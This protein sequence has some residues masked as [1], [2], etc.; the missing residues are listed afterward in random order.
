MSTASKGAANVS[1]SRR[2][3]GASRLWAQRLRTI[4]RTIAGVPDYDRYLRHVRLAHPDV[5][6]LSQDEFVSDQLRRRYSRPGARC[7]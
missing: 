5:T 4:L 1:V 7:C 3:W 6:P 2:A